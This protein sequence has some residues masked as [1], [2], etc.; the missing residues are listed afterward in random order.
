MTLEEMSKN[1]FDEL[2]ANGRNRSMTEEI[3]S[4]LT[5]KTANECIS[6]AMKVS[7]PQQLWSS[8]WYEGEL[9]C[10]FADSNVGKSIYAVQMAKDIAGDHSVIYFD[11]ELSEKQF[12]MRYTDDNGDAYVFPQ[13]LHRAE[14]NPDNISGEDFEYEIMNAIVDAM[15]KYSANVLIID[16]I[17]F[18]NALTEHGDA[19]SRLMMALCQIKR[20][21]GVSILILAHTPKRLLSSPIT[22]N[23]LAGSKRLFN[24]FDSVFAIG[25]S[26]QGEDMRYIKQLKSRS[27]AID[28]GAN[29][30]ITAQILKSGSFLGMNHIGFDTESAHLAE[31]KSQND[32][33][34]EEAIRLVNEEHLTV[35]Q[36]A[37]KLGISRSTVGR[38]IKQE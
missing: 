26:A 38:W 20:N 29:N 5:V 11:F 15:Q 12:Q 18:L 1:K 2:V 32:D 6:D 9:C 14:I 17:T 4:L 27:S 24:F 37:D 21:Y 36:I 22:Q 10:L 8:L 34:K 19:A 3:P 25:K 13:T 30:V 33:L 7:L 28:Y 31:N 35:R 23:D 16:N